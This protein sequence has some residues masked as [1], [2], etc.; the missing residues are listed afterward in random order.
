MVEFLADEGVEVLHRDV[1]ELAIL[2]LRKKP[3]ENL[4]VGLLLSLLV[5]EV[6]RLAGLFVELGQGVGR[7]REVVLQ[8]REVRG[9]GFH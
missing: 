9:V 5:R 7:I 6:D 3:L 8:F 4:L 1:F 2:S